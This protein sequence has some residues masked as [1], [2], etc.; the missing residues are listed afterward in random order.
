MDPSAQGQIGDANA[1]RIMQ[2]QIPDPGVPYRITPS[3]SFE[4]SCSARVDIKVEWKQ[5]SVGLETLGYTS[6]GAGARSASDPMRVPTDP[7]TVAAVGAT[8]LEVWGTRNAPS[9]TWTV[10]QY[11]GRLNASIHPA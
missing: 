6:T 10:T 4:L 1:H 7:S 9:G 8:T 3:G 2:L 11:N 5:G